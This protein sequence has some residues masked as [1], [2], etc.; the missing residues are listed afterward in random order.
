[1]TCYNREKYIAIAIESVLASTYSDFE[2]IIVDDAS[3]DGT[4][5]IIKEYAEKDQRIQV[6]V[7][8]KNIGDYPNRNKA[9][10]FAKGKYIKYV[11]SDDYI[12]ANG[13]EI[14]VRS[15]VHFPEAGFGLCS[16]KPDPERP[17]PFILQPEDA[18]EYHF[19]GPGLFHKGPLTAIFLKSA[20]DKTGGFKEERMISD[21]DMW[22]RM[23]LHYP[24]VLMPDGLVWQRRHP[25]QELSDQ[26]DFIYA[27][28]KIKWKYLLDPL[29]QLSGTQVKKIKQMR[30]KR[31]AGFILSG[32]KKGNMKQVS[33]YFKCFRFVSKINVR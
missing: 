14:M 13:L 19:F 12:Y 7:N 23:A 16:L 1:M 9:A 11:D 26:K 28:E 17:F 20:F 3:S 10:S 30:L 31:Y 29:C 5:K 4:V 15:M 18:Y 24:V 27:G 32:L 6:H 22:H 21:T 33:T 25:G 8:E 2:L